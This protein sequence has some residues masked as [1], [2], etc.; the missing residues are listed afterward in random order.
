MS[1]EVTFP[2]LNPAS[3]LADADIFAVLQGGVVKGATLAQVL[4]KAVLEEDEL[5][6]TFP[7]GSLA[8]GTKVLVFNNRRIGTVIGADSRVSAGTCTLTFQIADQDGSN[9][10]NITDLASLSV[11]TTL[12]E[13][14]ATAANIMLKTG[15]ADRQLQAVIGGSPT[16]GA[17]LLINL[18]YKVA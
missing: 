7:I 16:T 14:T 9:A 5:S 13:S 15:T 17:E 4:A 1:N 6:A 8:T 10:T 2:E 11:T 18:R 12:L 3:A